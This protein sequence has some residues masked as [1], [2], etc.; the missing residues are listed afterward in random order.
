MEIVVAII[1]FVIVAVG[2]FLV[3]SFIDQ[4]NAQARLLRERLGN[5]Q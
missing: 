1:A 5:K 3:F 4:R 2:V